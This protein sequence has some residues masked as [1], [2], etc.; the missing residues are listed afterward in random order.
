MV[1]LLLQRY[2]QEVVQGYRQ[3]V[4][5]MKC[6]E[7]LDRGRSDQDQSTCS[8]ANA[9]DSHG[10]TALFYLFSG[11]CSNRNS[12]GERGRTRRKMEAIFSELIQSGAKVDFSN[13]QDVT[14][15]M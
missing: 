1:T 10:H 3:E 13:D 11:K 6:K 8:F 12:S 9:C 7:D 4:E 15:L 14:P 5:N 2:K